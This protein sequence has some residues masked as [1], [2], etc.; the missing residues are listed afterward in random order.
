MFERKMLS[1]L[2]DNAN[3]IID[4]STLLVRDLKQEIDHIFVEMGSLTI[5]LL[6]FFRLD[7]S[8]EYRL[9]LIL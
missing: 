2:K 9:M 4:T 7:I 5:L 8:M 6:Q 1:Y 3:Y